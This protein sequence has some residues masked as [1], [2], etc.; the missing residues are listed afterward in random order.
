MIKGAPQ[1]SRAYT[2]L[3][4]I[5][6]AKGDAGGHRVSEALRLAVTAAPNDA[7]AHHALGVCLRDNVGTPAALVEAADEFSAAARLDPDDYGTMCAAADLYI[8]TG[9]GARAGHM[10][11]QAATHRACPDPPGLLVQAAQVSGGA[12]AGGAGADG[13]C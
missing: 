12:E 3:A 2:L 13:V 4:L 7:R 8:K 10:L 6:E 11:R 9:N 1:H 5:W